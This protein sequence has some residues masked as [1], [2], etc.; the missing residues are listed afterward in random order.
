MYTRRREQWMIRIQ[1][2]RV[3]I[4]QVNHTLLKAHYKYVYGFYT[5]ESIIQSCQFLFKRLYPAR[6]PNLTTRGQ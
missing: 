1:E 6:I 2:E 3:R 5:S 4:Q